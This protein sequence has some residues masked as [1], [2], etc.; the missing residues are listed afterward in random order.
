MTL[1][2]KVGDFVKIKPN[3]GI[4]NLETKV[5]YKVVEVFQKLCFVVG[6][7]GDLTCVLLS[8][9]EEIFEMKAKRSGWWL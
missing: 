4:Y 1:K 2:A 9:L 6:D 3:L 7:N 8:C 5:R